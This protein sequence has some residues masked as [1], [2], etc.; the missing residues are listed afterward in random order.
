MTTRG[1]HVSPLARMA[2]AALL[3]LGGIAAGA[4]SLASPASAAN[5]YV[6]NGS[7]PRPEA[8]NNHGTITPGTWITNGPCGYV[9]GTALAGNRFE[10]NQTSEKGFHYGRVQLSGGANLCAW[11]PPGAIDQG[12][13][14]TVADSCGD[15]V[16]TRNQNS[17]LIFGR[18]FDAAP[19]TG[20]GA[21]VVPVNPT[22][23]QGYFNY[24]DD[25]DFEGGS[26][27][28]P[29][30]FPL[31]D[32][33]SGYRYT[34]KDGKASMIRTNSG[35][36]TYWIFVDRACIDAQLPSGLNNQENPEAG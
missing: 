23:C 27:R 1:R 3:A 11:I 22:G 8:C 10:I 29:V 18:D 4:W 36:E 30:G 6:V 14:Q 31:T 15:D 25:S 2:G 12:S 5:S 34:S 20:D 19:H 9:V 32:T 13:L 16:K 17:R 26:L 35:G 21:I 24:F 33:N 7:T 28:D